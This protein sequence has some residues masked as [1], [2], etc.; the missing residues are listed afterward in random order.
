[1]F[2]DFIPF[3]L[4]IP[5]GDEKIPY[6]FGSL[7][8]ELPLGGFMKVHCPLPPYLSLFI[9]FPLIYPL[10]WFRHWVFQ[11]SKG[12]YLA[13]WEEGAKGPKGTSSSK[14]LKSKDRNLEM[15]HPGI[16]KKAIKGFSTRKMG[17]P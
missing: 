15:L 16:P 14:K 8:S 3:D 9:T 11:D 10:H 1:V 7:R 6:K 13:L 2:L 5:G 4:S 17:D 12:L